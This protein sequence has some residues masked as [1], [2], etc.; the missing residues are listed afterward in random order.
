[1]FLDVL[2]EK[3]GSKLSFFLLIQILVQINKIS[4]KEDSG[5][6]PMSKLGGVDEDEAEDAEGGGILGEYFEDFSG[7]FDFLVVTGEGLLDEVDHMLGSEVVV[8]Y[9]TLH[10]LLK[11]YIKD[12]YYHIITYLHESVRGSAF[13]LNCSW[14]MSGGGFCS[15]CSGELVLPRFLV[16]LF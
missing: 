6:L 12:Y 4:F 16:G 2:I 1:M 8:I 7:V 14:K 5:H 11:N 13:G 15:S 9:L 10:S 3:Q